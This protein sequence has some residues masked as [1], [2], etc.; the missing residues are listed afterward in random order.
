[1]GVAYERVE[2]GAVLAPGALLQLCVDLE[3]HL[4][5]GVSD[6]LHYPHDVEVVRQ[7]RDRDVGAA[8][9]MRCRVW[10]RGQALLAGHLARRDRG[11]SQDLSDC[12]WA[13]P[14]AFIVLKEVALGGG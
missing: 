7:E 6:L 3:G 14:P 11:F 12:M 1:V 8:H 2:L 5:V 10:Q 4:R 9:R 13:H